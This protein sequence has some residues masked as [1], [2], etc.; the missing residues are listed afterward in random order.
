M[1]IEGRA[2]YNTASIGIAVIEPAEE[3]IEEVLRNA[4]TAMYH[5]K[6]LGRGRHAFFDHHMH[7]EATRRLAL[8]SDLRAAIGNGPFLSF[9]SSIEISGDDNLVVAKLLV[10]ELN[11]FSTIVLSPFLTSSERARGKPVMVPFSSFT[12]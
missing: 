5:A 8:T 2:V 6:S 7:Y 12:I 1:L 3:R 10:E 9:F 4:D 11:S